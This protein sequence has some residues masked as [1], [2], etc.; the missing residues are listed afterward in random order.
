MNYENEKIEYKSKLMDDLYKEVIAFANTEGGIIYIGIDDQGD[1]VGIDNVDDTYNRITNGIRDAILP[2]VTMFVRYILQENRVIQI[3]VGE[4]SYKPYYLKGKGLK[5]TGVFV[6]QGAST[7]P[8]S[9]EKIR[10]MIKESDG[11]VFEEM[12]S[13]KQDLAFETM[14]RVFEQNGVLF[15]ED[16]FMALGLKNIHDGQFTNL[17]RILSDQCEHTTKVGVFADDAKTVFR[18]AKEFKG[19]IF[20]QLDDTFAYLMLCNRTEAHIEGLYRVESPDYPEEAIREALINALIHREYGF[21]GSIIINVN[22]SNMEFIS[23]GGLLSGLSP[24]DIRS[25]ISLPRNRKLAE[26]FHRL[27][28]IEAYGTGIRKIFELY[29]DSQV[30]PRIEVTPNTFKLILPNRNR[31]SMADRVEEAAGEYGV[32]K[33]RRLTDQMRTVMDALNRHGELRDEDVEELLQI[34]RTRA[35]LL[36]RQMKEMELIKVEGRGVTKRYKIQ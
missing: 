17:A 8:A 10:Q 19:S 26:I 16:K 36:M 23:L 18:D 1:V 25:G 24:E 30:K 32:K 13:A 4:G 9:P 2:D 29:V 33:E 34:K 21:S 27:K 22:D 20:R 14:K 7:V 5:P 12:R 31:K 15:S 6:R 11:D 35:Y 3:E 28:L